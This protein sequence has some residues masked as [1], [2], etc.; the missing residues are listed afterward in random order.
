M[1]VNDSLAIQ[2][3][4]QLL[5]LILETPKSPHPQTFYVQNHQIVFHQMACFFSRSSIPIP[6][7]FLQCHCEFIGDPFWSSFLK[8]LSGVD[9]G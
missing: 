6:D 1:K 2:N 4:Q 9:V 8:D 5:Q 7:C 3:P